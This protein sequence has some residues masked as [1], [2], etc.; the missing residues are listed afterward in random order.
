MSIRE[1]R[2]R[3]PQIIKNH[4]FLLIRMQIDFFELCLRFVTVFVPP[5]LDFGAK[6]APKSTKEASENE[7]RISTD[8]WEGFWTQKWFK[9]KYWIT[10]SLKKYL[11]I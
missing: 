1:V 11:V 2:A 9:I 6:T 8:F 5:G 4:W 7:V 10:H 3:P